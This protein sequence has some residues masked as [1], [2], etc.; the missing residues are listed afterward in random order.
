MEADSFINYWD[1][2]RGQRS[3]ACCYSFPRSLSL[4]KLPT[5]GSHEFATRSRISA[6][7]RRLPSSS[8]ACPLHLKTW[9]LTVGAED[10]WPGKGAGLTEKPNSDLSSINSP[11]ILRF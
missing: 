6:S 11:M 2:L 7:T 3:L 10:C 5:N 1:W 9:K 8:N 4:D